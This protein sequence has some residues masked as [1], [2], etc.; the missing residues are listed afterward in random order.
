M[1]DLSTT[2]M[3][4]KLRNPII[5][6]ASEMTSDLDTIKRLA[7]AGVG[8]LVTKS[9]FEEQIQL[10]RLM[11][12]EDMEK[13]N[14][15]HAEMISVFPNME[16]AGP[17]EH[18]MWV[19]RTKEAVDI[20]VI[21]SLNA[22]NIETWL[23]YAKLLEET[24]V[25]AIECNL[26]ATP[27][28]MDSTGSDIEDEQID[29]V[30]ELKQ[31]VEIPISI[32]LSP[33]YTNP[34]NV[35]SRLDAAGADAFV[36]FNRSFEPDLDIEYQTHTSPFNFSSQ[37]DYRLPLR[38]AG[39]LDGN[40]EADI[41]A[42][43]G[44]L[45]GNS[46]VKMILAGA[47]TIQTVTALYRHGVDHVQKML[48]TMEEWMIAQGYDTLADFRGGLSQRNTSEPWAYT[49]AQYAK[50]LMNPKQIIENAPVV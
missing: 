25:D 38:Y 32:K 33:F 4:M 34:L 27:M 48:T 43:T 13:L 44:I 41:C 10:E 31:T 9:L 37:N 35:I 28:D 50:L 45:N 11:F 7:D 36:L 21:A 42:S 49:R 15:R 12:T 29:L 17:A 16:F 20:P 40:I 22:I 46:V 14:Y 19:R 24:G 30:A 18:L 26:F 8:A 47:T 23:K 1:S 5:A 39:L 2:Y 6:G 3:G